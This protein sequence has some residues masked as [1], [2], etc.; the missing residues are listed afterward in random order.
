MPLKWKYSECFGFCHHAKKAVSIILVLLVLALLVFAACPALHHALH[1]DSG[2]PDHD[3][4]VT[5][6]VKGQLSEVLLPRSITF[7][8][9][10]IIYAVLL[11]S[12]LPRLLFE[13]RLAPSRAPPCL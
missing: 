3:C 10:F 8:A 1:H 13:Y 7:F 5:T 2:K 12:I 11:P 4:L 9:A 6:F